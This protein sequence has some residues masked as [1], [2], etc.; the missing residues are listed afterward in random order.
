MIICVKN[1][2][3]DVLVMISD[4]LVGNRFDGLLVV[5]QAI[6]NESF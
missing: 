3:I 4:A 5:T 1:K 2:T 6:K